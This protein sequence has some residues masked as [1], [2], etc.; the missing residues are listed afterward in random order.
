MSRR[1]RW[2]IA[3]TAVAVLA[4]VGLGAVAIYLITAKNTPAPVA[5]TSTSATPPDP[6]AV[7]A[8]QQFADAISADD[9]AAAVPVV[10]AADKAG[11]L[12]AKPTGHKPAT[13]VSGVVV[14]GGTGTFLLTKS[15]AQGERTQ[16]RLTLTRQGGDWK[17]CGSAG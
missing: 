10:C 11:L 6:L 1:D 14:N 2:V 9:P 7:A 5:P 13:V 12:A 3:G 16:V 4:M 17:V 15:P 8:A